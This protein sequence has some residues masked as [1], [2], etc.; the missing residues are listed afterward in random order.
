LSDVFIL[1]KYVH[2]RTKKTF[3]FLRISVCLVFG[4]PSLHYIKLLAGLWRKKWKYCE[5]L[6]V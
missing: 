2:V 4:L 1:V 6:I 5:I 3:L